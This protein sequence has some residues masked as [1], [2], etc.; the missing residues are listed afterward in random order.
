V[1]A[2][3]I[4]PQ[5]V[6]LIQRFPDIASDIAAQSSTVW[7]SAAQRFGLDPSAISQFISAEQLTSQSTQIAGATAAQLL[8]VAALTAGFIGQLVLVTILSL[9]F[10]VEDRLLLRQ[11]YAVLP[12]R[13]HETANALLGAVGR[14]FS[15]YLRGQVLAALIR[16]AFTVALLGVFQVNFGVVAAI[17]YA[18]LSFI[19]LIG[20]IFGIVIV[21]LVTLIV[22]PDVALP[23]LLILII[24]DQFMAYVVLPRL[25]KNTVGVP[26]LIALLSVSI[27]V[28]L[29]GFWGLIFGVPIVGAIYAVIFDFY[30][31][32]H[33]KAEGLP[34]Q[35]PELSA[36]MHPQRSGR[37]KREEVE[38]LRR[39]R[40]DSQTQA[41]KG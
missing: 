29:L 25:M 4:I 33:R 6:D 10:V 1:A 20:S 34:E 38:D 35:D 17:A 41:Q 22:R 12:R 37:E 30:L 39:D 2:A 13:T 11:L 24:F 27:G 26:G 16:G 23:V 19:P 15:G 32:R 9:F 7:S 5:A 31:P 36:L 8:S 18:L 3:T 40:E 14:S 21:A 28:Q